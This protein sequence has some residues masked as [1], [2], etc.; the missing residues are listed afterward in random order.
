MIIIPLTGKISRRNPPLITAG[1]ILTA[2][3]VFFLLQAGEKNRYGEAFAFYAESGLAEIEITRYASYLRGE[4]GED[5]SSSPPGHE[6]KLGDRDFIILYQKMQSDRVFMKKLENDEIIPPQDPIYD[7]WKGLRIH[8]EDLLSRIFSMR[9]GFKPAA[10]NLFTS[11]TYMFL[12]GSFMHL[13]GNMVFLWLVGCVLE[14]GC[15]RAVYAATYLVSGVISAWVFF[16][17]YSDSTVPLIGASGAISGL[18]GAYTLLYGKRKIRVF[19]S[20]GFYFNYASLSGIYLLP[21]WIGN[22]FFQLFFGGH[23]QIA[24]VAHIGGLFGGALLGFVNFKFLGRVDERVFERDPKEKLAPL[25]EE[26]LRHIAKLDMES[27]RP[28]LH[29]ILEIEPNHSEALK[30]LFNIDKLNPGTE[31]FQ[32]TAS[33]Y[34]M[35]LGNTDVSFEEM[36]QAYREYCSLTKGAGLDVDLIFRMSGM[37]SSQG[38]PEES[39]R[40]LAVLLKKQPQFAKIPMGLLNLARSY[41]K[42]GMKEKGAKCLR[43]L[44]QKYPES[45]ECQ[46]ARRLLADSR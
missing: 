39:E 20:L 6:K 28:L 14:L 5:G 13:F 8:Y 41:L 4:T 35:H 32:K 23:S 44:C 19:Y 36:H 15:G 17:V 11:F 30:H 10:K 40:I 21:L 2:C 7:T 1:I 34:L 45:N 3:F 25:L 33:R 37:F 9:Y 18:M 46:I 24:Y 42:K 31:R 22:E 26:A 27:A 16:L 38:Y 12:H 29:E 43:I